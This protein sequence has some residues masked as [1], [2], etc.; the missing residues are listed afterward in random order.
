MAYPYST[1]YRPPAPA[2]DIEVTHPD[3]AE[4]SVEIMGKID[5]GADITTLPEAILSQLQIPPSS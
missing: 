5:T 2:L 4:T 3:R 1:A